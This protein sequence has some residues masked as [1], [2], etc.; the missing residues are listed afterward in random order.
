K[1]ITERPATNLLQAIQGKAAGMN[2]ASNHKPGELP[3]VRI[4]GTRSIN[5]S[6]DPLYVLDGIPVVAALG[7]TSFS[8][9]DINPNDIQSIEVLKDASATAI[10]GSRG[11][12]GVILITT[13]KGVKG[14]ATINYNSTM[15]I[16]WF[17]SLTD[18]M[19]GGQWIDRWRESLINARNYQATANTNLN[20]APTIGYPD[21]FIDRTKMGLSS[22]DAQAAL[23]AGYEWD[24]YGQTPKM[25]PTTAAEQ[26]LGWP[27]MV[28]VY[29]S[30][31]IPSFDWIEAATRQ[32]FTQNHQ[33][34]VSSGNDISRLYISLGYNRQTGVQRDQDFSRF[35]VNMSGDISATKW[36]TMGMSMM[37]SLSK[38]NFGISTNSGNTGSKDLY[39]RA[40][41][42]FPFAT[43]YDS[44]GVMIRN[45][46]GN[47]N[48]WNPL[49]DIFESKNER[50]ASSAMANIFTEIKFTPWLKYRVNFGAQIRHFRAGAWTG[51][52][53]TA[54]L[55]AKPN[56]A[57]QSTDENFSWV[58]ENLLF[59]DKTFASKHKI[60]VTL[61]Q[62]AQ[63]SRRETLNV[64]VS[65]SIIPIAY[66]YDL[67][68]NTLGK[69]E[70]YGSGFTE[71]TLQSY[72]ARVNYSF[73]DRYLLTASAR[74]DG[75][76][77]L[78]PGHKWDFFPSFAFAWK[79]H[80]ESFLQ[81]VGWLNE[82]KPRIGFGVTG[83]SS[84]APYTTTGPLSRNPYIFGSVAAIGYLPQL[85]QNPE[86][87]WE[88]T[89]QWNLGVDFAIL[90]RRVTGSLE[91]YQAKTSDLLFSRT[92][93]A[94][95]GYVQKFEN[96]G[97]TQNKGVEVTLSTVNIDKGDFTWSTDLNWA[98]NKEEITDLLG[99]KNDIIGS[100]LFIGQPLQVFYQY[101]DAGIWGSSAKDL[102]DM[103]AFNANGHKFYP[104]MV[105]VVDQD[106]DH[107][108]NGND[109]VIRG[110]ARPKW[111][112]GITNSFRYKN[113]TLSSFIYARVG[114]TYFGG[115]PNSYGGANPNGRVEN[116]VWSWTT[117][118]G[119]WPVP[120]I[121]ANVDNITAAM[122]YHDGTF[123][124][125]R[126]IS[127]TWDVP[128]AWLKRLS[129]KNAQ[130]NVQI[131]NPFIFGGDMIKMGINPD[132]ETNWASESQPNTFVTSPLGGQNNNTF[133]P[134]SFVF[135]L[136]VGF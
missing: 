80:E 65:N 76:S 113:W 6:N 81:S 123:F 40:A 12:N 77:V 126:N 53:A 129:M 3:S 97:K 20:V 131:L 125:V 55:S 115:Y 26:A 73:N 13:K 127:L 58:V 102:Q 45:A 64:N 124:A 133:L 32:G 36:L 44:S 23:F 48:L 61:L 114:Q 66:W 33:I 71:N 105:R 60:G 51:P 52:N 9:N 10:Y 69:P 100:K 79:A 119:K 75:A 54:H 84:V 68:A 91:F 18:W 38:Q 5:A 121:G 72:M 57:G 19:N 94:V 101:E 7:V 96:I 116:D 98:R 34:A 120:I 47:L 4:R 31:N 70:G 107:K 27:A 92:L 85:V 21:P 62:S 49:I 93:P 29:N 42:Q 46:G 43:P 25:R 50:R 63:K 86:L 109:L 128:S 95:S 108:I 134:Q 130:L 74:M 78:A 14:R 30:A 117:G 89:A 110:T 59:F 83:N 88:Q 99:T 132:D 106:G 41:D 1:T 17:N 35:N 37:A 16:D 118:T 24:V 39:G 104:G 90:N 56:T 22:A 135:A 67:A 122:Q 103:A 8:L 87:G 28:P 136:R 111:T 112:G 82:L 11:A 15:Q 2:V